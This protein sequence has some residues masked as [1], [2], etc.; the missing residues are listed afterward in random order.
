MVVSFWGRGGWAWFFD[1]TIIEISV[2]FFF[3]ILLFY[4][5]QAFYSL[6]SLCASLIIIIFGFSQDS[7]ISFL[8]P[9]SPSSCL[10]RDC[11]FILFYL[12]T[13]DMTGTLVTYLFVALSFDHGYKILVRD[14]VLLLLFC[15]LH[16]GGASM[17]FLFF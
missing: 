9:L 1:I 10:T 4:F 8:P 3:V 2:F 13:H 7:I 6:M 16:G 12:H 17:V 5:E 14:L 11:M 15:K